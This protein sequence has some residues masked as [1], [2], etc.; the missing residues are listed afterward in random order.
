MIFILL[1]LGRLLRRRAAGIHFI[2]TELGRLF[3]SH[4]AIRLVL[5]YLHSNPLF[6]GPIRVRTTFLSKIWN[7]EAILEN[8]VGGTTAMPLM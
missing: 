4:A 1:K 5:L 7:L 3:C 8:F 6:S 2:C